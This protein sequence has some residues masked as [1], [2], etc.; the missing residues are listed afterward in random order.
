MWT[1]GNLDRKYGR[2][3]EGN[4]RVFVCFN[5]GFVCMGFAACLQ[6]QSSSAIS[7]TRWLCD[8]RLSS[9]YSIFFMSCLREDEEA[10][11]ASESM[12]E[13]LPPRRCRSAGSGRSGGMS[14]DDGRTSEG[15]LRVLAA[16]ILVSSGLYPWSEIWRSRRRRDGWLSASYIQ[17]QQRRTPSK[18]AG[19]QSSTGQ[20][21]TATAA[22]P[23]RGSSIGWCSR[24]GVAV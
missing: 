10:R 3:S 4:L 14:D 23:R 19:R 6:V 13:K 17:R 9:M 5:S 7:P 8:C 18:L 16:S 21:G 20:V 15:N 11:I 1:L 2:T 22:G 24:R 12:V